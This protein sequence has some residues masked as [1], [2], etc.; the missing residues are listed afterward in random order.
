MNHKLGF[1]FFSQTAKN[2]VD[3]VMKQ[4]SSIDIDMIIL[5]YGDLNVFNKVYFIRIFLA[6]LHSRVVMSFTHLQIL[7]SRHLFIRVIYST[8]TK[9][10]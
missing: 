10:L 2:L 5:M 1:R 7:R 3:D 6:Q 4:K 9:I 8:S